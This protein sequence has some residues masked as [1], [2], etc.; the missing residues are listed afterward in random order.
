MLCILQTDRLSLNSIHCNPLR[1]WQFVVAGSDIYARVYDQRRSLTSAS[2]STTT[3][4]AAAMAD[5]VSIFKPTQLQRSKQGCKVIALQLC[6]HAYYRPIL[7]KQLSMAWG[8]NCK[9]VDMSSWTL[10]LLCIS[11][12]WLL[13]DWKILASRSVERSS[14]LTT[15]VLNKK[16][17]RYDQ[18][19]SIF[20]HFWAS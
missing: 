5:P 14:L 20:E 9:I 6:R 15:I 13:W 11:I 16:T 7:Q 3:S 18:A 2:A 12:L 10:P 1:P 17:F 4:M 8:L 19:A